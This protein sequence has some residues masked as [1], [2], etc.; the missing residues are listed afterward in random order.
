MYKYCFFLIFKKIKFKKGHRDLKPNNILVSD[1]NQD[2]K[3]T[4]F[5]VSKF[6]DNYKK[7]PKLKN[8]IKMFTYTGTI[9]FTAPEILE[10]NDAEYTYFL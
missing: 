10:R 4:D 2:V 6:C 9:A 7:T 3:I 1:D 8:K 5:N